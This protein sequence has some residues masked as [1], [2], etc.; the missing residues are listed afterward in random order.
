MCW[1]RLGLKAG[2]LAQLISAPAL[3]FYKP[4][5][6]IRLGLG[7]AQ[8]GLKPQLLHYLIILY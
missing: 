7:L 6:A 1:L 8:L 2:S 3:K 5:P 4:S